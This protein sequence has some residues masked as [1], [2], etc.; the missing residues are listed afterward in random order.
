MEVAELPIVVINAIIW[1]IDHLSVQTM[2]KQDTMGHMWWRP[3]RLED[4][5][6]WLEWSKFR[7]ISKFGVHRIGE[8]GPHGN[9]SQNMLRFIGYNVSEKIISWDSSPDLTFVP[10]DFPCYCGMF[11]LHVSLSTFIDPIG[12]LCHGS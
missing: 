4:L 1:D 10:V 9:S 11:D 2:K 7:G 5:H 3:D 8:H 12:G 6:S